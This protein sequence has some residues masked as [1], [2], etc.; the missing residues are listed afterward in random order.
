[1]HRNSVYFD[2]MNAHFI[3]LNCFVDSLIKNVNNT[4][5]HL[6]PCDTVIKKHMYKL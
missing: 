5:N 3:N 6:Y 4:V 1:M 2:H